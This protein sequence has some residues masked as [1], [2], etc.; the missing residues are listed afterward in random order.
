MRNSTTKIIRKNFPRVYAINGATFMCDTRRRGIGSRRCF[1]S[2]A[3]AK[4]FADTV[5]T[6]AESHGVSMLNVSPRDRMVM[7]EAME[8]LRSVNA[9]VNQAVDFYL[10]HL[11]A[12]E[13]P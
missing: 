10:E 3:E 6:E 13:S 4:A 1:K 11:K 12:Q 8:R 9:T 7:L 2:L 5:A